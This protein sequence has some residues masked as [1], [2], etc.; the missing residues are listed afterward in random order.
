MSKKLNINEMIKTAIFILS[1]LPYW[2]D[3]NV[4]SVNAETRRTE[5]VYYAD[6]KDALKKGFR[7][8]EN[9]VSLNGV[10]DFGYYDDGSCHPE[11]P[12]ATKD[13]INVPG[14]WEVQRYGVAIY[15]NIPYDFCP[16][17][18]QP[19]LLPESF[20]AALYRRSFTVPAPLLFLLIYSLIW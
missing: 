20:P 2:Q 13:L 17:N 15:T 6:K 1:V 5:V 8:S 4:T 11:E 7:E 9:Y 16:V 19:P 12:K 14:N 3:I 18:P 10:W